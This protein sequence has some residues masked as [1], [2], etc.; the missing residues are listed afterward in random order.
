VALLR[1][2]HPVFEPLARR[3]EGESNRHQR[4]LGEEWKKVCLRYVIE[5]EEI[6]KVRR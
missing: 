1:Q 5:K 6:E 4:G 2:L 3:P